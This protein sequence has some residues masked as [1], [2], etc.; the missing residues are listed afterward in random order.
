LTPSARPESRADPLDTSLLFD[1]FAL[2]Q[3]V[4]RL[5]ASAMRD[6]PL[7]PSEYAVYSAIFELESASPT[8]LSARLGMRLTTFMDHLRL[9]EGRGHA[10]RLRN[11]RDGRSY[12][13]T[14]T[15]SGLEAHRAANHRFEAAHAALVAGLEG[16]ETA[17][18]RALGR[19]RRAAEAALAAEAVSP[20]RPVGRAG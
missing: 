20:R 11:P 1:V 6:G 16:G 15:A 4:G 17:A 2:N 5:L 10:R 9:V 12:L 18:K 13:V 3:A 19:I 7:T 8:A 14:L